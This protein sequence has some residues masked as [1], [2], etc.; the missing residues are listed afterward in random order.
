MNF[1]INKDDRASERSSNSSRRFYVR[2][3]SVSA[4]RR[5]LHRAPGGARVVGRYDRETIECLHTMDEHS[6]GRHWPVIV[7][8]LEKAGLSVTLRPISD[9]SDI[10]A[11]DQPWNGPRT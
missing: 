3:P 7:S 6:Y 10:M 1:E 2:A 9:V 8:R 4:V 11:D 5:A